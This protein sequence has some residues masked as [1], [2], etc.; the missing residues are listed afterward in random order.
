L[1]RAGAVSDTGPVRK[2]NEDSFVSDADVRLFAVA[3]GM[4]GHD[5]GEVASRL[6]IEALTAFIRRSSRDT[7]FSWPYGLDGRLSYDG[8]RLRTAIHLA[9]RRIFREAENNDDYSGM[10]TTIV[11]LLANDSHVAIGHVG[12]SRLY[13][14]RGATIEQLTQD[15]SWAATI[16]AH[17]PRVKPAD[18][19]H[20]PM[21]NVLTNVLGAREQLDVH[22]TERDLQ[23][24]DVLLLCS[25]GLHGALDDSAVHQILRAHPDVDEAAGSLVK[26]ALDRGSRDNVTALVVRYESAT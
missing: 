15:D 24:G 1:L 3:D 18:L 23:D 19:A 2:T 4:G 9:N 8:N 16:L 10:G 25:D 11:S 7:D 20:H 13:L 26:A 14:A 21:R 5:A 22:L 6:A 12:D 17:D